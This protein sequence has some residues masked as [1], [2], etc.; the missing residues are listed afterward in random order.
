MT[1]D[2]FMGAQEDI[3]L[4]FQA[5]REMGAKKVLDVGMTLKRFGALD[6]N[7]ANIRMTEGVRLS[8]VDLKPEWQVDVYSCIYDS[9]FT[10]D[11][12][13]ALPV[14]KKNMK[15]YQLAVMLR[16][17]SLFGAEKHDE[18]L[19]KVCRL[20]AA[21]IVSDNGTESEYYRNYGNISPIEVGG[22]RY[23]LIR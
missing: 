23:L 16:L 20:S 8:G 10:V 6:R 3:I 18:I 5:I 22:S 15:G 12:F 21:V 17:R 9:I 2:Y 13:I 14:T 4:Y 7:I 11:D 1:S 19:K